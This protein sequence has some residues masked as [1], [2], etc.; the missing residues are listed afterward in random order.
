MRQ[1]HRCS[2]P[3]AQPGRNTL[4]NGAFRSPDKCTG[5]LAVIIFLQIQCHNQPMPGVSCSGALHQHKSLRLFDQRAVVQIFL[6]LLFN[7][8]NALLLILSAQ[9][10]FRQDQIQRGRGIAD[11]PAG[12]LP[13]FLLRGELIAGHHGPLVH[14]CPLRGQ[15]DL[16]HQNADTVFVYFH[17]FLFLCRMVFLLYR[18]QCLFAMDFLSERIYIYT[19]SPYLSQACIRHDHQVKKEAKSLYRFLRPSVF[20][21]L[22]PVY[23]N[24]S[25]PPISS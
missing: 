21:L 24:R 16:R 9:P 19:P 7:A 15:Q 20:I 22:P 12:F 2:L 6:H 3:D 17:C 23:R 1:L 8:C 18:F 14:I 11:D 13:V 4:Y 25:A 10:G 5:A